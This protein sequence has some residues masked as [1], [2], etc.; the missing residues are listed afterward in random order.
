M[1]EKTYTGGCA[2]GAIRFEATGEPVAEQHCQ[3]EHCKMRSGTG[4][5]S[6]AVFAGADAVA[7][8]GEPQTW[9]VAGDSGNDKI[10]AFCPT[11]GTPI[12]VTFDAMPEVTAVHAGSLDDP[13]RFDPS[14]VTYGSR[15]LDWDRHDPDLTVFEKMPSGT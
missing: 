2:C 9:R 1:T 6:Y 8:T 13:A 11:C 10:Y 15:G 14:L 5:S 12:H 3:C 7:M 4:H